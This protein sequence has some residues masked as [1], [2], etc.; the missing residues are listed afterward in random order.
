MNFRKFQI[1]MYYK[2][3]KR[4]LIILTQKNESGNELVYIVCGSVY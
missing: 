3:T 2:G 4:I 1:Y